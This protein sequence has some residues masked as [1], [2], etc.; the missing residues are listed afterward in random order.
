M[1]GFA[2]SHRTR[3]RDIESPSESE[4]HELHS[5]KVAVCCAVHANAV[6]GPYYVKNEVAGGVDN[7]ETLDT[8]VRSRAK[9]YPKNSVSQQDGAFPRIL[10]DVRSH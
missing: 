3:I 9:R 10:C 7:Y 2:N 6:V 4:Q 1:S 5:Q 8:Y